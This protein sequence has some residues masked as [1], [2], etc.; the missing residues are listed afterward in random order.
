[1]TA[2]L[3][4]DW[5]FNLVNSS[6][7]WQKSYCDESWQPVSVPHDWSV[8]YPFS[9]E[10]S[11]G[12]GYL[13]GG[14]GWYRTSFLLPEDERGKKV[15]ITFDGVYKNSKVW[16]NSYYL[17]S[18]PSGYADFTYDISDFACFGKE[19]N[20][21]CVNVNHEDLSDSRWFTGSGIIRKVTIATEEQIYIADTFFSAT[22]ADSS[23]AKVHTEN[24]IANESGKQAKV[25]LSAVL[26][27]N[28]G[29]RHVLNEK[30][31]TLNPNRQSICSLEGIVSSPMLWAPDTPNL[32]TLTTELKAVFQNGETICTE[33]EPLMV[34]IRSFMFDPDEG[35]FLNGRSMK[36]KG[37]CV[38]HDA[39]GLGAAVWPEVWERRL[40][41]L[42]AMGCNAIR[43]SHNPHMSELYG[44][45]DRMGFLV[46]DEAFDEWEGVKNKWTKGHN[47]YPPS[48]YGYY[49]AFP[50]WHEQ[51]LSAMIRRDRNHPSVILWSIGNEVDYPNDPYCH[52]LFQNMTGN[53][54]KNKPAAERIYDKSK[55]NSQRLVTIAKEL[56]AIVR[57]HDTTR[58]ILSACAFP[59]LSTQLGFIEPLDVIG[60]NY[61]EFLY[62]EDHSRF[63]DKPILGSENGHGIDEWKAVRDNDYISA[64]FLWTGIDF[65]GE[66]VG[67][68]SHGSSAGLLDLA[69]N[70]KTG[71]YRRQS[72]WSEAPV[73]RL[74]SR[75][76][77]DQPIEPHTFSPLWNY[78]LG[79]LVD[80][81]CYTNCKEVLLTSGSHTYGEGKK[82]DDGSFLWSIPYTDKPLH[83]ASVN[84]E[85]E[86]QLIPAGTAVNIHAGIWRSNLKWP[87]KYRLFQIEIQMHDQ[88]GNISPRDSTMLHVNLEGKGKILALENGDLTDN[89]EYQLLSRRTCNGRLIIYVLLDGSA[90][91]Y[92]SAEGLETKTIA[93]TITL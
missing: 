41:K 21:I 29:N 47:V 52:P 91:I 45:C 49:E 56:A 14:T 67:W 69:G 6:D 79:A 11:S 65:L 27:D 89:T 7:P 15:F 59:E 88:D 26:T 81:I 60:Y 9:T 18:R 51:D 75:I 68:P 32:Y 80:V 23:K 1:M 76:H 64:Q 72:L 19:P 10:Y 87:G 48:H 28:Q 74:F 90:D 73:L 43:M 50:Q 53:N 77:S 92:I 25:H 78:P 17:G 93:L 35:F 31:F 33:S 8:E 5:R 58:P 66:T 36:I 4:Q 82:N 62:E 12:T 16:C 55:P 70:E 24:E 40:D 63:P 39:G 46:M 84:G 57:S 71:Y 54:D 37:V 61:K 38:H 2:F 3:L 83:A 44:L 34:G 22:S 13:A 86:D 30:T 20:V 85:K 42:K